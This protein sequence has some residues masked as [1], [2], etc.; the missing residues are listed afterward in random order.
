MNADSLIVLNLQRSIFISLTGL[1]PEFLWSLAIL[2]LFF[3]VQGPLR[4]AN[5]QWP[6][7]CHESFI[8][9]WKIEIYGFDQYLSLGLGLFWLRSL[10]GSSHLFFLS[11]S[12]GI[13]SSLLQFLLRALTAKETR[14]YTIIWDVFNSL[15]HSDLLA[16]LSFP[17]PSFPL[18]PLLSFL[19]LS[20]FSLL[21][22]LF[23]SLLPPLLPLGVS[24]FFSI[25]SMLIRHRIGWVI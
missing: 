6:V 3:W 1:V 21:C 7:I 5:W 12:T 15:P 17:S 18:F 14:N 23:L 19:F 25:Q 8:L 13:N 2:D 20:S 11:F 10:G 9:G 22:S 4:K 24:L 16:F